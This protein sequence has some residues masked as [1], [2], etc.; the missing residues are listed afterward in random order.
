MTEKIPPPMLCNREIEEGYFKGKIVK[1]GPFVPIRAW[2]NDG[3]PDGDG[4]LTEDE[5]WRC[6]IDGKPQDPY[7]LESEWLFW[8][9][10]SEEEYD[11]MTNDSQHAK[12][13]REDDAKANPDR[14][15]EGIGHNKPPADANIFQDMA[16]LA[17]EC[18]DWSFG[19]DE[20][21]GGYITFD[22]ARKGVMF[23]KRLKILQ[24]RLNDEFKTESASLKEAL[25]AMV[26]PYKK[27]IDGA[28]EIRQQILEDLKDYM[29]RTN[30][31]KVDTDYGPKAR[32][33]TDMVVSIDNP[34]AITKKYLV[35]DEKAIKV[36]LSSEKV[37]KGA[38]MVPKRK[39]IV[40]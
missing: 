8:T 21:G 25:S 10:I 11:F 9:T 12:A 28:E 19:I 6:A 18:G 27:G 4:Q 1:D 13:Y 7:A 23:A 22:D 33:Q 39:V 35:P 26:A 16:D 30:T 31:M 36:A 14:T 32:M 5:G 34:K 17:V 24:G 40:S 29:E 3:N 2:Y 20:A 15:V 38:S 37:V